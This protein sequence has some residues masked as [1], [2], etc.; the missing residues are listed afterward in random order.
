VQHLLSSACRSQHLL[1]F[2]CRI[3]GTWVL[4]KHCRYLGAALVE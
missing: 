1:S 4:V 3:V 2:A